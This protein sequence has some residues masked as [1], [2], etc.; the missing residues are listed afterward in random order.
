MGDINHQ[1]QK[2]SRIIFFEISLDLFFLLPS[3]S[4]SLSPSFLLLLL[5]LP[6][7]AL[8]P[9]I[10][11]HGFP[12]GIVLPLGQT[13]NIWRHFLSSLLGRLLL[14]SSGERPGMLQYV[15]HP[16]LPTMKDFLTQ[17]S[18]SAKVEK[19]CLDW[20]LLE[21]RRSQGYL[22]ERR[23]YDLGNYQCLL[24][25][26]TLCMRS[27]SSLMES[28]SLH[29][30]PSYL[31]ESTRV[32]TENMVFSNAI[33]GKVNKGP[34]YK[35]GGRVKGNEQGMEKWLE[36]SNSDLKGER[37]VCLLEP[38]DVSSC[39]KKLWWRRNHCQPVA[40]Q[41]GNQELHALILVSSYSLIS[42][43]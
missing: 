23:R 5:Y 20:S 11:G 9:L 41:G 31:P 15:G 2:C 25:L 30:K 10:L 33:W 1:W 36:D 17:N 40:Q 38:S 27:M 29:R 13:G 3:H 18:S 21:R 42:C 4:P 43:W 32:P 16:R 19:P 28:M 14:A 8:F 39:R 26:K 34:V 6:P 37:R 24:Y 12:L 35:A 7:E 22:E